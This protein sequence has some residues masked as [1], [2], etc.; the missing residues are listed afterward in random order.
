MIVGTAGHI[1]HGKTLLLE[2]L[3][4]QQG[5]RRR[6]ERERGMTIDLGYLYAALEPG[7]ALTGFIDVPGHERFTH[8]MLAGAQGIDLVLLV[9]AADDGV[10]PQTR[11]HL[12][13]VELLGIPRALVAMT[14]C[15]RVEP[16]RVE[17][18][19]AQIEALL[20]PGPFAAAPL[21]ALSSVTGAGV[22]TLREALLKVQKDVVQRSTLGGFRLAIDRAFSVAGAGIVVT[23]TALSGAVAVGDTL[24]LGP[25]GKPVRVRG[26]H[27]QN[28]AADHAFAGQRVA[29]NLSADRL[30]LEQ[31]HRGHWLLPEWLHAPTQRLDI[32]MQLL[33]SE[34]TAFPHFHPVHVHLGT[35]D[36]TGRV[37]LLEGPSLAPGARMFAQLLLNAPVHAVKG[38]PL[39]LRDQSAQRTIGGGRVLDPFAPSRHRRSPERLA[40]LHVLASTDSLEAVMPALLAHSDT[41]LDPQRLER[42]FNRPRDSWVL[43]D[44]VRLINTRQGPLLFSA[45]RWDAL[46]PPLLEHLARFHQLEPDQ[47]GPDRD[48]LRRFTGTALDRPTFI[49]LLDELLV[50]GALVSSGPWLHLP[51]HQ[52]RLSAE[53]EAL[54]E[55]LQPT[56]EQ[57]GFNP[58]WVRDLGHDE[59][60]VRAL[61]RKM[62]RL[63]LLHQVVRDLFYTDAV[64][65]RLAA[66]LMQLAGENPVIEVAAFRDA[67]GLGRKRSVQ[68]LEYFDR[69]GLTRRMG[70]RRQI[71]LDSALAQANE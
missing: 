6:E 26:L 56:F 41:G 11:E 68:I 4:G 5:D 28:Q 63:G 51:D 9:V 15:D 53:D 27:A 19:R 18:V 69:I 70:D 30:N 37:A 46:K 16:A 50:S 7:A 31:I 13:I 35:Q 8:N 17:E 21:I 65:R 43:P 32:D 1:D 12:A 38:D 39:I 48:R 34:I 71:R 52:V 42:Q 33:P 67:V 55:Q 14:K 54:W 57:A 2:A 22:E 29:L 59:A 23:G 20:A 61:L 36:V 60:A 3:T 66:M 49:S 40:Q 58:P 25:L 62:A 45:I 44:D 64:L 24:L 47:M 10:M